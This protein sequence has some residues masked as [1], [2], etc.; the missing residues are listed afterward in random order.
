MN[1]VVHCGDHRHGDTFI[2]GPF[3]SME[4]AYTWASNDADEK[5]RDFDMRSDLDGDGQGYLSICTWD[6]DDIDDLIYEWSV[7]LLTPPA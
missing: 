6:G 1:Y 7:V 5:A 3:T 2:V 4:A